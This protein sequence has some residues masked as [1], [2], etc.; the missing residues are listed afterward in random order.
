[1]TRD[2]WEALDTPSLFTCPD[3]WHNIPNASQC[4]EIQTKSSM[5]QFHTGGLEI[6]KYD[7]EMKYWSDKILFGELVVLKQGY[8]EFEEKINKIEGCKVL[9]RHPHHKEWKNEP[10]E[11]HLHFMCHENNET[12]SNAQIWDILKMVKK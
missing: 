12:K 9:D 8:E 5:L 10:D 4:K 7:P 1:M 3:V 2:L 11:M 6:V